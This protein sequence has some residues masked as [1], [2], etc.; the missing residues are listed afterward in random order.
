MR[1]VSGKYGGRRL[2]APEDQAIRPTSDKIRGAIFNALLSRIDIEGAQV[3]DVFCGSG[4]LGLEALSR[5]GAACIFID[6]APR[7]LALARSNAADLGAEDV[8]FIRADACQLKPSSGDPADLV[9]LDPPYD[10]ALAVPALQALHDSSWLANGA[11]CVLEVE[12]SFNTV[13]PL[14]Y[15]LLNEK[16]YGTTRVIYLR[17]DPK[18]QG[19]EKP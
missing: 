19:G 3:L 9:F 1:I 12:S 8:H 14:P 6:N 2:N 5:G 10:K 11:V 7:S 13:L 4:A 16:T 17:Y 15:V 18:A